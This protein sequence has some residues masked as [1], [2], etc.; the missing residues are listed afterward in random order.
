MTGLASLD[1]PSLAFISVAGGLV[2]SAISFVSNGFE[3]T[4][5]DSTPDDGG[6]YVVT[7]QASL[8]FSTGTGEVCND[9][10]LLTH[11]QQYTVS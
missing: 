5:S 1:T 9:A 2:D 7:Y 11:P 8:D 3:I 6:T 4:V 10:S